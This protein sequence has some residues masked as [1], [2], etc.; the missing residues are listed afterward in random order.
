[1]GLEGVNEWGW[2][3]W[4]SSEPEGLSSYDINYDS[5]TCFQGLALGCGMGFHKSHYKWT[6]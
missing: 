6:V 5:L 4:S 1:M 3:L 2:G